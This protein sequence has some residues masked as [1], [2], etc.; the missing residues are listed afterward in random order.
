MSGLTPL[1][2]L[3]ENIDIDQLVDEF[4]EGW[5]LYD[6]LRAK[7]TV[8]TGTFEAQGRHTIAGAVSMRTYLS[9]HTPLGHESAV[10]AVLARKLRSLPT[11]QQAWLDGS[12][13]GGQVRIISD[14]VRADRVELF[15]E[16]EDGIVPA[17]I[18]Q[19]VKNTL[20]AMNYWRNMAENLIDKP[21]SEPSGIRLTPIS[22]Q[23][24]WNINGTLSE[25][26][27][28]IVNDMI[29]LLRRPPADGDTTT[30]PQ[31]D[32]NALVEGCAFV[33][34][35]HNTD[36]MPRNAQS[37]AIM[38]WA[39][40][41]NDPSHGAMTLDGKPIS[42]RLH[43]ELACSAE[44][45]RILYAGPS[46]PVDLGRRTRIVPKE[47]FTALAARD[48]GCRYPGCDRPVAWCQAHH[49]KH[50]LWNGKTSY[51]SSRSGRNT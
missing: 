25:R 6:A 49:V 45:T 32:A 31:R 15:A 39:H 44:V 29:K 35:Q 5:A 21:P 30:G 50:W 3:I 16:H 43:E 26:D 24:L 28:K 37:L 40:H 17:L 18:G 42:R 48:R 11:T 47:L 1:R 13:T 19:S 7:L 2:E 34:A 41:A 46:K 23:D 51:E 38:A 27:A 12:L 33:L 10:V 14:H 8:A 9:T 4:D 36:N 20:N 22:G